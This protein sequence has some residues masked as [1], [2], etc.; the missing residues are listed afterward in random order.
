MIA[1][2]NIFENANKFSG[3]K[4]VRIALIYTSEKILVTV[5]DSG[6]GIP[7]KDIPNVTQTFFRSDNA[8]TF[9]GSGVGLSLSQKIFLLHHG[10][11]TVQ[12]AEGKGTIVEVMLKNVKTS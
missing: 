8:R 11:L 4:K 12:S 3:N 6:I 10:K 9:S 5:G 2:E 7:E 1:F